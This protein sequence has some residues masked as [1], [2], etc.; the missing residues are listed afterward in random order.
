MTGC[1]LEFDPPSRSVD[2]DGASRTI[3]AATAGAAMG[4]DDW[5]RAADEEYRRLLDLLGDLD[6]DQW[7][8]PTDCTGWDVRAMVAHLAG[9]AAWA[10]RLREMMRQAWQ[11]RGRLPG[12]DMVDGMNE[13]QLRERADRTPIELLE[14]IADVGPR[15]VRAR[16]RL[17]RPVRALPVPFGP[18]L[19]TQPLG[20]LYDR[21]LTR[22]EWLHRI[23]IC[24]ALGQRPQLTADHDARLVEDV[25]IEW[26]QLHG[27]PFELALTGPAGGRWH[28][29]TGAGGERLELDAVEFCRT[30]SGRTP[31][32]GLL[33]TRVNF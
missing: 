18:P 25:V 2:P 1:P 27:Q 22:D 7:A 4:H 29:S 26:A 13:V 17:P 21:I 31:G 11:G 9:G 32:T 3:G 33:A 15:A 30:L 5:M 23:D 10:A 16:A 8:L 28:R 20:Y 12:A 6:A 14:E 24:R 19:G